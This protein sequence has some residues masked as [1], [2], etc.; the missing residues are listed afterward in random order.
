VVRARVTDG[1]EGLAIFRIDS[2][3]SLP[4]PTALRAKWERFPTFQ[5]LKDSVEKTGA[6]L[7]P[8]PIRYWPTSAGLG[9]YQPQFARREGQEPS[10]A[11]VSLAIADRRGAGHD[12]E[13]AWQ[14]LLGLSAP[15]ISAGEHGSQ[16]LE[17]RRFIQAAE[18]ALK[19]GD[20]EAFGRAWEGL[21]RTV[22]V[23]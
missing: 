10:L 23:P 9:A 8:G 17:A 19:R 3:L 21:K 4:D 22:G 2:L 20:L 1:W 11:W 12:L 15:I 18:A 7:E 5:Q 14:N 6:K 16:L 13:E